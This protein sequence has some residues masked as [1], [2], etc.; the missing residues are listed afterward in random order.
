MKDG[1]SSPDRGVLQLSTTKQKKLISKSSGVEIGPQAW[2]TEDDDD[3][4]DHLGRMVIIRGSAHHGLG[5]DADHSGMMIVGE[6]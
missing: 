5:E 4:D 2:G 3:N 1:K 6:G